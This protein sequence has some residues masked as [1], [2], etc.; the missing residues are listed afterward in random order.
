MTPLE[1]GG[2]DA[3]ASQLRLLKRTEQSPMDVMLPTSGA[4]TLSF[5]FAALPVL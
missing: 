2:L 3:A 5:P 1:L 4:L